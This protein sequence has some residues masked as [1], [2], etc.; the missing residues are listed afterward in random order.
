[1]NCLILLPSTELISD[2]DLV[3]WVLPLLVVQVRGVVGVGT[4]FVFQ[5]LIDPLLQR[6][7]L[8]AFWGNGITSRAE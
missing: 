5:N 7:L 2:L 4:S 6:L 3:F 1:M 8:S